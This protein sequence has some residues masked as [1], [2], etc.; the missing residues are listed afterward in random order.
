MQFHNNEEM[1]Y[2]AFF[3]YVGFNDEMEP[4]WGWTRKSSSDSDEPEEINRVIQVAKDR[5]HHI[6]ALR[7]FFNIRG[8]DP[9]SLAGWWV[10]HCRSGGGVCCRCAGQE[11]GPSEQV[12]HVILRLLDRGIG[13]VELDPASGSKWITDENASE[14]CMA[15]LK[16]WPPSCELDDLAEPRRA[17]L[18]REFRAAIPEGAMAVAVGDRHFD[19][20]AETD[21]DK[22]TLALRERS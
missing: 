12:D 22:L 21:G 9:E 5:G 13:M 11:K 16:A 1:G 20:Y 18:L 6:Q 8:L 17:S 14:R 15:A 2:V 19:L 10:E 7:S 3:G 4:V